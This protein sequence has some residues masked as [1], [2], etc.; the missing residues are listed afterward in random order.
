MKYQTTLKIILPLIGLLAIFAAGMG[1]LDQTPGE[2]F[3]FT[4]RVEK[5]IVNGRIVFDSDK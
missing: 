1:F 5:V 2:P 4:S 3:E